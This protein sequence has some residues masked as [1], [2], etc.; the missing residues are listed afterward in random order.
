MKLK[1]ITL[2]ALLA[3]SVTG[4]SQD[5]KFYIF[6][7][8]GQSNMEGN[9]RVEAQDTTNV[10][11]RFQVLQAVDCPKIGR[12]KGQWYPAKAPL[13]RCSTGLNPADYFG[14]ELLEN[15]PKDVRI[16]IINV[17]VAGAKIE[18]FDKDNDKVQA[19]VGAQADWMKNTVKEYNGNPYA[20]LVDLAKQ[21]QKVGVIKGYLLH[22][23]ESNP[24]DS[25]WTTKVKA[26]YDNLNADLKLDA[27]KTPLLAGETVNADQN[28]SCA[29]F[30]KIMA[31]LP[32]KIAN[33]YVI[34]S[35]GLP[36]RGDRLHFN[37]EGYRKFGKRYG[38][39]M[40]ALLGVKAPAV[41]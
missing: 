21:A 39:K 15:L 6:L 22:Q 24:N 35:A 20:Y 2:V 1:L 27:K 38:H 26:L 32:Q 10:D 7:A 9:A 25:L 16:G 40:L 33:S 18:V 19:Y 8:F 4:F 14:R 12:V 3:L 34:S 5:K 13:C 41:E 36:H 23:G 37:A 29:G 28:G 31:T 17:S 30:N 11:P